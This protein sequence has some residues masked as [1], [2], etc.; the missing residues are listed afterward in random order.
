MHLLISFVTHVGTTL[1]YETWLCIP[2]CLFHMHSS[3]LCQ[4]FGLWQCPHMQRPGPAAP[5]GLFGLLQVCTIMDW[6]M[7]AFVF[8]TLNIE[9]FQDMFYPCWLIVRYMIYR[10]TRSK[11]RDMPWLTQWHWCS[12]L[13]S[14]HLFLDLSASSQDDNGSRGGPNIRKSVNTK[15]EQDI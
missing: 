5:T 1:I 7:T 15:G 2:L 3:C 6:P 9:A 11:T 10:L 13:P 12:C 8:G 4:S 14:L